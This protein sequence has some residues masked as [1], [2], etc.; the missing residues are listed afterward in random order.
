MKQNID[1][2]TVPKPVRNDKLKEAMDQLRNDPTR[3]NNIVVLNEVVSAGLL[4]PVSMDREPEIDK[5]TGEVIIDKDTEIRFEIISN[6]RG[7]LYYP[8]FTD[9]A[10]MKKFNIEQ[11]QRVLI[12]SFNDLAAMIKVQNN[13]IAGFVINPKSDNMIFSAD[14]IAKMSAEMEKEDKEKE[15]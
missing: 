13:Q 10:E 5:K 12:V 14:M 3:E 1:K 9:G 7:E 11:D 8:V 15:K 6:N 2:T 4:A